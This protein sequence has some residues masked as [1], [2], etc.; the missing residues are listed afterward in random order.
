M[1][2]PTLLDLKQVAGRLGISTSTIRR[3]RD[4]GRFPPAVKISDRVLRWSVETI[5]EYIHSR[6]EIQR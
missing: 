4:A 1:H 3:L 6:T 2:E 5:E